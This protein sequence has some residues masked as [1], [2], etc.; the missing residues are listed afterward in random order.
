MLLC[1]TACTSQQK[2]AAF[3]GASVVAGGVAFDALIQSGE[4]ES[5]VFATELTEAELAKVIA[6]FDSYALSREVLGEM[7]KSPEA[8]LSLRGTIQYEHKLIVD[9]YSDI[10]S[11]VS[12]NWQSYTPVDQSRLKRWQAQA[13]RLEIQYNNFLAA[14]DS[15]ISADVRYQRILEVLK[16]VSQLALMAV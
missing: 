13:E 11:V 6:A 12:D 15:E 9:A 2:D 8:A 10:Q 16:I 1:L 4:V 7:A 3:S 5:A 14:V